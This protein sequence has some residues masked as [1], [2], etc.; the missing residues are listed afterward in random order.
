MIS[1]TMVWALVV[2]RYRAVA[3]GGMGELADVS[4]LENS[5]R[6]PRR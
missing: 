5:T 6:I 4:G 2:E 1:S 3:Q